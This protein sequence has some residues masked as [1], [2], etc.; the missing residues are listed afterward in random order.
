M[1]L[2]TFNTISTM[3]ANNGTVI[4]MVTMSKSGNNVF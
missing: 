3:E 1:I 2:P 4:G